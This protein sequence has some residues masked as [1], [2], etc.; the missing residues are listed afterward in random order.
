MREK[1]G[2]AQGGMADG[3][4]KGLTLGRIGP[5]LEIVL[6]E[7]LTRGVGPDLCRA[8]SEAL[9][10]AES[11]GCR[12]VLLRGTGAEG[13]A[14][15]GEAS[16]P[17]LG[18]LCQRI[19]M[20]DC[21][22]ILLLD[23]VVGGDAAQLSLAAH[24][25]LVGEGVAWALPAVRAGLVPSAG[26][27]QRLPRLVGAAVALDLML[28]GRAIDA[29]EGVA[30]GIF[31][32]VLGGDPVA[33]ARGVAQEMARRQEAA[34]RRVCEMRTGL[35][36]VTAYRAAVEAARKGLRGARL[37]A[38]GRIV[39]CV[40]AALLLPFE[41]GLAFEGAAVED[42]LASAESQGLRH[43]ARAERA[44]MRLP[45]QLAGLA[46]PIP[47]RLAIW[48]VGGEATL[49]AMAA[50]EAGL[51]VLLADP[52]REALIAAL[53]RIAAQQEAAV[54]A[55]RLSPEARDADWAR[56]IP[57]VGPARLGE[58]DVILTTR[59]D[60]HLKAPRTVLALGVPAQAGAVSLALAAG[61]GAMLAEMGLTG[62]TVTPQRAAHAVALARRLGW[63]VVP[64]GPGGPVAVGLATALAEAV[65]H[66]EG[67]GVPRAVIAQAL[68]LAG[69][70]GEG[71]AGQPRATE[72][73]VARRC[74]GALANAGARLVEAGTA[75]D[76]A[77]IDAVA[78][79]AGIMARW[80][81][82]PM[83]QADRRGLIVLR[84][85]LRVWAA[86][87][88]DL[89]SPAPLFDRLIAEGRPLAA[90]AA[91]AA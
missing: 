84:R 57:L 74:L 39:D 33:E 78:I 34:L 53:E 46:A 67:R 64:V 17:A 11:S 24:L 88:P 8:L 68:A 14:A 91:R 71:R 82:G 70:A 80:T 52:A 2:G 38:P 73:A 20:L 23:K 76:G 30:T 55:G 21:P 42:L 1:D 25:R 81:G 44:A 40:E 36:D 60:L 69:I 51:T 18:A 47:S 65:T 63:A 5:V 87:A 90:D 77:T 28:S 86:E 58:G 61:P 54:Q 62:G 4:E 9:D 85:D 26:A 41:Q 3:V 49:V 72:E 89:F 15:E 48:G 66:L 19:E 7:P 43:A 29:A 6:Q 59:P 31:D 50:L 45:R 16:D 22:V 27:T 83:L 10:L 79:G 37:P 32:R 35:R 56:L 75:R 12:A 13:G